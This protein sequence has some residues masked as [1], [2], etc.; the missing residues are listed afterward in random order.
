M[1]ERVALYL[2][3][4]HDLRDGLD[5][6]RYA[7]KHGFESVWQAESRLVRDA[8]VP[9]AAYAA[10]TERIK[11]GS[12][13]INNWTRNIGLLAATFLTL[14]DLAPD[15]I[16]C[17]IGAWWDPLARDVGVD[18]RKPLTAMRETVEI[19]RRLLHMERVTFHGEF[20]NV[21]GIELDVV[22][23][24]REPRHVPIMIGATGDQMMEM[25]GE[26]ADG[27]VLNYC[28]PPDYN[29]KALELLDKGARRAGRKMEDLDRPQL[30]VCSVDE[31]HDKA[32]D[33]TR[34]LLTQ[35]LAQQPHIAKAS[36]VSQDIVTQI[37][38]ILGWPATKEQIQ[39]AKHLVP[40][41]LIYRITAS[42]TP[43]EARSKVNEYRKHGATCPILY[44]VGGD[45][46]LLIDTFAQ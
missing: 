17:G 46:K 38:S 44:P 15:R 45:V 43:A 2:Q 4:A 32:I 40:D 5:Y 42:G 20:V 18:R 12:G 34:G 27:A 41:D 37:Q 19:L 9:M 35:Y 23:G 39:K 6:V 10:V 36:G 3:D 25:T 14:D 24:R 33:T 22:H 1:P 7:E 26:I 31:D 29:D 16:I 30:V 28:V 13:V 11:V 21:E 8:I